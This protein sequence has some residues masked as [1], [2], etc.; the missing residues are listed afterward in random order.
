M[1]RVP[2][3]HEPAHGG[4]ATTENPDGARGG[5]RRAYL[6]NVAGAYTMSLVIALITFAGAFL[7]ALTLPKRV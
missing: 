1:G 5:I 2:A 6:R 3:E 7:L 4:A